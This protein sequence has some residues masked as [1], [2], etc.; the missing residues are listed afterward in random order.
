MNVS[1]FVVQNSRLTLEARVWAAVHFASNGLPPKCIFLTAQKDFNIGLRPSCKLR[2]TITGYYSRHFPLKYCFI[3][4][5]GAN[6]CLPNQ[7]KGEGKPLAPAKIRKSMSDILEHTLK[8][9][10]HFVA[11]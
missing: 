11:M 10:S 8:P 9:S 4:R 7:D 5:I 1:N 6:K 3:H 2:S